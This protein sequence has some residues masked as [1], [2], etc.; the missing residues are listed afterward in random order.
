MGLIKIEGF[1]CERC[2]HKWVSKNIDADFIPIVCPKCKSPYWNK[3][4]RK[5]K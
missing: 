3:K 4:R 2:S 5:G 1:I